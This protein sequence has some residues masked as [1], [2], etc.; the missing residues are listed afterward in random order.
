VMLKKE[1]ADELKAYVQRGG[2]LI[3]EG[4]PGYFGDR[5]HVG[6]VQP[7]LGLDELFGAREK[8]VEF[9]PDLSEK[10]I[11][12]VN[13]NKIYGRYFRQDYDLHGGTMAGQYS[14]GNIAA[15]ANTFGKGKTLL[16]GSFPGSGY[17]LH[18]GEETRALFASFLNLAGAVPAITINDNTVQARLNE[19]EGGTHIWVT[20]STRAVKNVTVTLSEKAGSFRSAEDIWGGQKITQSGRQFTVSVPPRDAVVIALL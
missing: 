5:G 3:C 12:E 16:M 20:N 11:F 8:F 2:V 17:Y 6:T 19:G 10:L 4:T 15:V 7:N 9:D 1:T 13:G 18:H 14:N